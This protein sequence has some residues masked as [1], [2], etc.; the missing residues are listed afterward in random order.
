MS[1]FSVLDDGHPDLAYSPLLRAA[2]MTLEYVADNGPIPLTKTKAFRR[3]FLHWA[4]ENM[5]WPGSSLEELLRYQKVVNEHDFAP[6]ELTHFLLV[7][8]KLARHFKDEFRLT[9][10]GR[11]LSG[12]PGALFGDLVPFYVLNID[13]SSYGRIDAQP[14]GS[15][16]VW[17]NV[18]NVEAENG[19][20]ERRLFGA[21]YGEGPDWDNAGFR[22]MAVF[23][24]FVLKPLEWSGLI[25]VHE[26]EEDGRRARICFKTPLWRAALDLDTD[27][28]VRPA[29]RH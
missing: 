23:S 24:Q 28:N 12:K 15:W 22:E 17:L 19:V 7:E 20:S 16:D 8:R 6:L 11:D 1:Y 13:H 2:R 10:K 3:S 27:R 21:F 4:A 18:I 29:P 26:A 25:S 14:A 5:H 9:R